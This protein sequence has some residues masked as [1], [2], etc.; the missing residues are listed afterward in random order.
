M[1]Y[2]HQR[3]GRPADLCVWIGEPFGF[4]KMVGVEGY[5]PARQSPHT[6][7]CFGENI[8]LTLELRAVFI[9]RSDGDWAPNVI[10]MPDG[11]EFRNFLGC[12]V[13]ITAA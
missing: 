10:E 12:N 1:S 9:R 11:A 8:R 13:Q 5:G 4:L 6:F 3:E 2:S 7:E